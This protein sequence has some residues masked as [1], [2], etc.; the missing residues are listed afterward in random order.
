MPNLPPVTP[1]EPPAPTGLPTIPLYPHK[2]SFHEL[3]AASAIVAGRLKD[4]AKAGYVGDKLPYEPGN[5]AYMCA[6][7]TA[8]WTSWSEGPAD[9][10]G[11][12]LRELV[13]IWDATWEELQ[14]RGFTSMGD[15]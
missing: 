10:T 11:C 6:Q 9:T 8:A 15:V 3:L 7:L 1:T 4:Q 2:P 14:R 13:A 12:A 5:I